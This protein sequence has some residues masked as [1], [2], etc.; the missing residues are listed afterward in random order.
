MSANA[1]PKALQRRECYGTGGYTASRL[2]PFEAQ[3]APFGISNERFKGQTLLEKPMST[4]EYFEAYDMWDEER[5]A[6]ANP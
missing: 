6:L 2:N 3:F 4:D 1:D 5:A